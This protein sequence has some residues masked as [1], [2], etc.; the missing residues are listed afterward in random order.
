MI[1]SQILGS[2]R[3]QTLEMA[4]ASAS[5]TADRLLAPD[6]DSPRS[7][8]YIFQQYSEAATA[9]QDLEQVGFDTRKLSLASKGQH[10]GEQV[11]GFYSV[12]DR[13]KAW[14]GIGRFW[15]QISGL[16][17]SPAIFF[18]PGPGLILMAGPLVAVLVHT[19]DNPALPGNMSAFG[20]ALTTLGIPVEQALVCDEALKAGKYVLLVH[21]SDVDKAQAALALASARAWE[22]TMP[23]QLPVEGAADPG[24][25]VDSPSEDDALVLAL[26]T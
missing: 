12:G 19:L 15:S 3:A 1:D 18:L 6:P 11:V 4:P 23:Y 20:T 16:M 14:G 8:L 13:M 21:G 24:A 22:I 5:E 26:L 7:P 17:L 10:S 25:A 9:V 2:T